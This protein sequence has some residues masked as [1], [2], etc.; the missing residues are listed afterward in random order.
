MLKVPMVQLLK[1]K[2]KF[3]FQINLRHYMKDAGIPVDMFGGAGDDNE[4]L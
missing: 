2:Y 3:C 1:L 4:E